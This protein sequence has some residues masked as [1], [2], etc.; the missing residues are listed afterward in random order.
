MRTTKNFFYIWY[1]I[2]ISIRTLLQLALPWCWRN[3]D[4]LGQGVRG[5]SLHQSWLQKAVIRYHPSC[6][7]LSKD[8]RLK[9]S[10]WCLH[11][12]TMDG[13]KNSVPAN[14]MQ[15]PLARHGCSSSSYH[16]RISSICSS[17]SDRYKYRFNWSIFLSFFSPGTIFYLFIV[18]YVVMVAVMKISICLC[19]LPNKNNSRYPLVMYHYLILLEI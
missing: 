17:S 11:L 9:C 15:K 10:S 19:F 18:I 7:E 4:T 13:G 14:T 6:A 1:L 16:N 5:S 8:V 2:S 3:R 12:D